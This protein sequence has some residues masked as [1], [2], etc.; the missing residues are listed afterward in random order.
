[1]TEPSAF[2]DGMRAG[3][4]AAALGAKKPKRTF[5]VRGLV[6]AK[7]MAEALPR[8]TER[9]LDAADQAAAEAPKITAGK[10]AVSSKVPPCFT[11]AQWVL[12]ITPHA[13]NIKMGRRPS[14]CEDC[15]PSYQAE[16][17]AAKRCEHPE[18][19]F[20]R[21]A[22]GFISGRLPV[23]VETVL[24]TPPNRKASKP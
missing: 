13:R 17:L 15:L 4:K 10:A 24:T 8:L 22:D 18:V 1:M 21:D 2:A 12:W 23:P 9:C 19:V 6:Y 5:K 14:P 20:E 7:G 11:E 16:M 3:R